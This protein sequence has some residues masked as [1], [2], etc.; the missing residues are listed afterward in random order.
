MKQEIILVIGLAVVLALAS[1]SQAAYTNC[2]V[3][4]GSDFEG[5][6]IILQCPPEDTKDLKVGDTIKGKKVV[7][8]AYEGC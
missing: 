3:L 4:D 5:G 2:K 1:W 7:K 6:T 8:K